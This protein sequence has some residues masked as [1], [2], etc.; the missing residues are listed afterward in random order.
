[1][2]GRPSAPLP[3]QGNLGACT[4]FT[5]RVR[6]RCHECAERFLAINDGAFWASKSGTCNTRISRQVKR[7]RI[8][9]EVLFYGLGLLILLAFVVFLMRDRGPDSAGN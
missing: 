6:Y 4:H 1:M 9:R 5:G 8:L 7:R 2:R 3:S